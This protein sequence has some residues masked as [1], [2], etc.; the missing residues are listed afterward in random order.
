MLIFPPFC[1][2]LWNTCRHRADLVLFCTICLS[3]VILKFKLEPR[4]IHPLFL[5]TDY[6]STWVGFGF[7]AL[8]MV[9]FSW[10]NSMNW[11]RRCL[12]FLDL[13]VMSVDTVLSLPLNFLGTLRKFQSRKDALI[14]ML[15]FY[16]VLW[17]FLLPVILYLMYISV[18][19]PKIETFKVDL[20]WG[21]IHCYY[22]YIWFWSL[23]KFLLKV[24]RGW[25]GWFSF[26]FEF[27]FV[28][29][30]VFLC[31]TIVHIKTVFQNLSVLMAVEI[32]SIFVEEALVASIGPNNLG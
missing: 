19:F 16:C 26:G 2:L 13:A 18:R 21:F 10:I 3:S 17:W 31:T 1:F 29:V 5:I 25:I 6:V 22:I 4:C 27:L 11:S 20:R 15:L 32:G 24:L 12:C 28:W 30:S 23:T 9:G 14:L 8:V 7:F